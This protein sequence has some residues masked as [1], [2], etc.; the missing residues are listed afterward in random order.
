MPD[1]NDKVLEMKALRKKN[2]EF[3]K[4]KI[5]TL[6]KDF[7]EYNNTHSRMVISSETL[8]P[9]LL[10]NEKPLYPTLS[11]QGFCAREVKDFQKSTKP[12][13]KK[14]P[15][16]RP[17]LEGGFEWSRFYAKMI[18]GFID[19]VENLPGLDEKFFIRDCLQQVFFLGCGLGIH[20]EKLVNQ[21]NIKHIVVFETDPDLFNAS[22]LVTDWESI[23]EP[24][25]SDKDRSFRFLVAKKEADFYSNEINLQFVWMVLIN[26]FPFF[27][28]NTYFYNHLRS[29]QYNQLLDML[30]EEIRRIINVWGNYDDEVNQ[31]NHT[32]QNLKKDIRMLKAEAD[33]SKFD[34]TVVICG[35][36][37]SLDQY[38]PLLKEYRE[39]IFIISSG[40]SLHS[41]T[42]NG[43]YSDLH[44][45]VESDL[46]TYKSLI[47]S[48]KEEIQ[49][50]PFI[51]PTQLH[52]WGFDIFNKKYT[53]IKQESALAY[54]F[55]NDLMKVNV[56]SPSCT[57]A[58]LALAV[59]L[60]IS[61][62]FLV[63]VD[64]GFVHGGIHH[65]KDS[66]YYNNSEKRFKDFN[67][68]LEKE[69]YKVESNQFGDIYTTP[70]MNT[71]RMHMETKLK[72]SKNYSGNIYNLSQGVSIQ[73][74]PFSGEE[75]FVSSIKGKS[76]S[77]HKDFYK[78]LDQCSIKTNGMNFD[79]IIAQILEF[80]KISSSEFLSIIDD[81]TPDIDSIDTGLY[82][83]SQYMNKKMRDKYG[84]MHYFV[85][86]AVWMFLY[87]YHSF[88]NQTNNEKNLVFITESWKKWFG[89][90]LENLEVHTKYYLYD[91]ERAEDRLVS[92]IDPEPGIE[93]W[94]PHDETP[95]STI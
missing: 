79:K 15:V 8:E 23:V 56:G 37:P 49:S 36:G 35:N 38:I 47:L 80:L 73:G 93:K 6:Y 61:K 94:N 59:D 62:V 44:A 29:P 64:L 11:P 30:L 10:V 84:E 27:P 17:Q 32:S 82:R 83:L 5:P 52:P 51:G 76:R 88:I 70:F 50:V 81:I 1:N 86:G 12:G 41:L 91:E 25:I 19:E 53:Y 31:L 13:E 22:L 20:I 66:F 34:K 26:S 48:G 74:I 3:F 21:R 57:N 67:Q 43:I 77:S 75:K 16:L 46:N 39:N 87:A 28:N 18:R 92:I 85:R 63:G 2:L 78:K 71:C 89:Y 65:S 9:N 45:E 58:A 42:N 60:N 33:L 14:A 95:F 69:A 68:R 4:T 55:D 24:F 7:Y 90:F 72:L 40:S 54:L